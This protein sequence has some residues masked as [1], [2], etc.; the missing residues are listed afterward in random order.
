MRVLVFQHLDIEH[1]GVIRD[2]MRA[3]GVTWDTVELD[4]GETIPDLSPY[5]AMMVMGGPQD[6]WQEDLHPWFKAEKAAIR[7][8]VV[9]MKRPY[10]GICLGHQLLADA[11]GGRVAPGARPEVGVLA[12][13]KLP[14]AK[15]DPLLRDLENPMSVLQWHGAEVAEVPEGCVVLASSDVCRVQ[16]FRYGVHAY[17]LQFHVEVTR[18]TVEEWA[19][20]PEYAA[21]LEA[22]LGAGAVGRLKDEVFDSLPKFNADAKLVYEGFKALVSASQP[23]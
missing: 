18:D 13:E 20:V 3:D 10:L 5:D 6:T 22:T 4:R 11:L 17:G 7:R 23:A 15:N 8:F 14:A 1:P 12:V 19:A 16:A 21:A 2:F 9:E